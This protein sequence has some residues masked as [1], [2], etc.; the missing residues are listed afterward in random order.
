VNWTAVGLIAF[1]YL[2]G[3]MPWGH[4]LV[5]LF[6]GD[7]I[8]KQGSG[9]IGG[10]NVWRVHG[11]YLGIAVILLDAAKG[12][13]PALVATEVV[14]HWAGVLAGGAAMLGHYR[15]LFLGFRRGGKIVATT[16][17][18]LLGV[19]PPVAI[20]AACVWFIVFF[21]TR[22]P[23]VASMVGMAT[24]GL[25]AWVLGY[26]WPVIAL[27]VAAGIGVIVLHRANIGRLIRG[28]ENRATLPWPRETR[29]A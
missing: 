13:I 9:N 23:S 15:P 28:E 12:F 7:D 27:G 19:A 21:L 5:L 26:P 24:L 25:W 4:W 1:G 20:L 10:T 29:A 14:G 11:R 3:S 17:G 16:G 18:A 2:A 8:R 6:R 22:Y